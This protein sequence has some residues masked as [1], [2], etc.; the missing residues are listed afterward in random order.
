MSA[1][2]AVIACLVGM[3]VFL[4]KPSTTPQPSSV[5]SSTIQQVPPATSEEHST[6]QQTTPAV[7]EKQSTTQQN[8][9]YQLKYRI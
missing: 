2:L 7:A 8:H 5:P 3:F 6:V 1:F 4:Q 9:L